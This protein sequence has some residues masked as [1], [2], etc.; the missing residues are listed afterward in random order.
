MNLAPGFTMTSWKTRR[1]GEQLVA[2]FFYVWPQTTLFCLKS[3]P[4]VIFG[5]RLSRC[6]NDANVNYLIYWV[7]ECE[8]IFLEFTCISAKSSSVWSFFAH[9]DN[10]YERWRAIQDVCV[11]CC[12]CFISISTSCA[13]VMVAYGTRLHSG[14]HWK[15]N[16]LL[17]LQLTNPCMVHGNDCGSVDFPLYHI[18][19]LLCRCDNVHTIVS[20]L[21]GRST[22][23]V[24]YN[25]SGRWIGLSAWP[26]RWQWLRA[27]FVYSPGWSD[28]EHC[29]QYIVHYESFR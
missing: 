5:R 8:G 6:E 4:V 1:F 26:C 7:S 25:H 15:H 9:T 21:V 22:D 16:L 29:W 17:F 12:T 11:F 27:G 14:V 28:S 3:G 2:G 23:H 10:E 24:Q 18:F 20:V 19:P 13:T